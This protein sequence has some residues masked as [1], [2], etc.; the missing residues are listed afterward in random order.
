VN[1]V[2]SDNKNITLPT[3]HTKNF[4]GEATDEN[5]IDLPRCTSV[6]ITTKLAQSMCNILSNHTRLP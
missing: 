3:S 2:A 1:A 4:C 5:A 6:A